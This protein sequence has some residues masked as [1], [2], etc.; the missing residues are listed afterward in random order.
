[1]AVMLAMQDVT[2][3]GLKVPPFLFEATSFSSDFGRYAAN[4]I[5][6]SLVKELSSGHDDLFV[7]G[8][9]WIEGKDIR[10]ILL[11][12][13]TDG[14]KAGRAEVLVPSRAA[15]GRDLKPQNFDE[16]MTALKEFADGAVTDGGLNL[17]IWT[18]KGNDDDTLVFSDGEILQLYFRVNQPS[19]LQVSYKLATG[20]IVLL[21][22]SFYIGTD[23]VNRAVSLPYEFQVQSPFGVEQLIVTA[24]NYEPPQP[25]TH[26]ED[27][28]GYSYEVFGSVKDVV[29]NTRGLGAVHK[30]DPEKHVAEAFLNLTT[31]KK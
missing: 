22:K 28:D 29:S 19:F 15:A 20:Q 5:E 2:L 18:N 12:V 14:T 6:S 24:Y 23:R 21:E 30:K 10:L 31:L 16:A 17:D 7:K 27:I 13:R 1:M 4:R 11:A 8:Q 3:R 9:Y 26:M 25:K